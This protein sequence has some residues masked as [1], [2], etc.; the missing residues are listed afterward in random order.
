[1]MDKDV[2][3]WKQLLNELY[4]ADNPDGKMHSAIADVVQ[5]IGVSK[6]LLTIEKRQGENL[7][8]ILY[9]SESHH[10]ADSI[11]TF[12]YSFGREEDVYLFHVYVSPEKSF[13]KKEIQM[14]EFLTQILFVVINTAQVRQNKKESELRDWKTG[15]GNLKY[16][17][18]KGQV[19]IEEG[20]IGQYAAVHF[21]IKNFKLLNEMFGAEACDQLLI[22]YSQSLQNLVQE[23][24]IVIRLGG[25]GYVAMI[26]KERLQ[27]FLNCIKDY[28]I[29]IYQNNVKIEQRIGVRA[30]IYMPD[31]SVQNIAQIMNYIT[32]AL[33]NAKAG[34]GEDGIVYYSEHLTNQLNLQ[35]HLKNALEFNL[36]EG[37]LIAYFQPKVNLDNNQIVGAEALVRWQHDDRILYPDEFIPMAE[38]NGL[39]C[40]IDYEILRQTCENIAKWQAE[41]IDVVP[42]SVNFSKRHLMN[43]STAKMIYDTVT[44]Y[45]IDPALI[46]IEF[47]ETA[48][49]NDQ[50]IF[51]DT[52]DELKH[53]GFRTSVDDF[54]A[55]SSNLNLL[56]NLMFDV[57]KIDKSFLDDS[58]NK[59][60]NQIILGNLVQMAEGL[61]MAVICEGVETKEHAEFLKS[62]HCNCVQGF[63]FDKPLTPEEFRKK[64]IMKNY[65]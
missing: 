36:E 52:V 42:I 44:K 55:G 7:N 18:K 46:E 47:T 20:R 64:L 48:F 38:R 19:L 57:L 61:S 8:F 43:K 37:E 17:F 53:Y 10:T 65:E 51:Q 31:G 6:I 25:D 32:M 15:I 62:I 26:V 30:G 23:D 13:S 39:V 54:G 4:T 12:Q 59:K 3:K 49:H 24:E 63:L 1:M 27:E 21:N 34:G 41:Q 33:S 16:L 50:K 45:Q 2:L 35:N 11:E 22:E 29:S 28:P 58:E 5:E 14:L 60:R 56:Q 9:T 40:Q